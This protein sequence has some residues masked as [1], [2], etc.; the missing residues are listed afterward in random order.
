MTT[1][2]AVLV[3]YESANGRD[4]WK[5]LQAADV[6][7]WVRHPDIMGRL[8]GGEECMDAAQGDKGSKWYR[9]SRAVSKAEFDAQEKRQRK[10]RANKLVSESTQNARA[11]TQRSAH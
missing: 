1:K 9:A 11:I 8:V 10:M 7:E 5:P 3:V 4:N 2:Q 6:P